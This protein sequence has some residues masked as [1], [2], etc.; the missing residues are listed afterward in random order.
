MT[1]TLERL[2]F[3]IRSADDRLLRSAASVVNETLTEFVIGTALARA[4]EVLATRTVVPADYFDR[5]IAALDDP[6]EPNQALREV[7]RR[8]QVTLDR[9]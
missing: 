9:R 7:L 2:N 5:L 4:D 8:P 6:P 1:E 3:R